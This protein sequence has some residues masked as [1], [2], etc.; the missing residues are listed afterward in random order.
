MLAGCFFNRNI[1][2]K[3]MNE[4][5]LYS[6]LVKSFKKFYSKYANLVDKYGISTFIRV[7]AA[8]VSVSQYCTGTS[9]IDDYGYE[10]SVVN[11]LSQP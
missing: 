6:K 3:P 2:R 4:G 1:S 9:L 8:L 10:L 5:F 11:F 7:F